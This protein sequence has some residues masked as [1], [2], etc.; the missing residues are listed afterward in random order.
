MWWRAK[1]RVSVKNVITTA[2]EKMGSHV[3]KMFKRSLNTCSLLFILLQGFEDMDL[4]E[5]KR[6]IINREI[7]MF[8]DMHKVRTHN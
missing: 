2:F 3:L 7:R 6:D 8:R 4:E 5:D 1:P